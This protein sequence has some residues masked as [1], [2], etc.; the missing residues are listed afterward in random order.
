MPL[1]RIHGNAVKALRAMSFATE[2]EL[3]AAVEG[4]LET[5]FGCRFVATEYS[6]GERHGGRIDTL[7]LSE[8]GNPVWLRIAL[9]AAATVCGA[10]RL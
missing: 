9:A 7:A 3:Q 6:T 8:D 5:I 1:S 10:R 2:K 4:N